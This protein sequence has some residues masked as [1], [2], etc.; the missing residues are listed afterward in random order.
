M[1]DSQTLLADY[2]NGGSEAAFRELVSRYVDLV[3][4]AAVRMVGGDAHLAEDVAQTVFIDLARMAGRLSDEVK[5]GGWLHRH[6]CFVAAK[7]VRGERRRQIRE[8]RAALMNAM[9]DHSQ[10]NLDQVAPILDEAIN[11]LGSVDRSAILLRFFERLDFRAIGEALGMSE[12]ATQKRVARAL[13]KLEGLLKQRGAAFSATALG[14]VLA[15]EAVKAAPAGLAATFAGTALSAAS[16]TA[17]ATT[18]L[19]IMTVTKSK[20][21]VIAALALASLL[22]S[23]VFLRQANAKS[24]AQEESLRAQADQLAQ[25][26]TENN[27][28]SS[29]ST[30]ANRSADGLPNELRKLR[31]EAQ[32]LRARVSV[33]PEPGAQG[34]SLRRSQP[35]EPDTMLQIAEGVWTK[36]E[37]ATAWLR[38]F[39]AYAKENQGQ[40][41]SSF[42]QAEPFWPDE[43]KRGTNAAS[44]QFEIL[45]HGSLDSLTNLDVIVFREKNLWRYGNETY[46]TGKYGRFYA[47]A[48]G[49]VQYCSSSDKSVSGSFDEYESGHTAPQP[50]P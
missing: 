15:T 25:L 9:Q 5:L 34:R 45:Y 48:N 23:V 13:G 8:T 6:T 30:T 36:Q 50:R 43:T 11:Q 3:Y 46:G 18:F 14:T 28:L 7:A 10:A 33:L 17:S 47:L 29:A 24:R 19:E 31:A 49:N 16:T 41:P 12:A 22:T 40:L 21:C 37:C 4:S 1:T 35:G 2:V 42:E 27:R 38:A 44:E 39:I 20:T 32:V 26:V